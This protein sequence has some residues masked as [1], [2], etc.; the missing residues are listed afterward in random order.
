[1]DDK[2]KIL[3]I[4]CVSCNKETNHLVEWRK[5]WTEDDGIEQTG[6]WVRYEI[7]VLKCMGCDEYTFRKCS[8]CSE[9]IYPVGEDEEGN[10]IV[11]YEENIIFY[12][13]R[14]NKLIHE[15]SEIYL[16][17][18]EVR[19]IYSETLFAINNSLPL[20]SG[21]GIRGIIEAICS[22]EGINSGSIKNK[23]QTMFD[24]GIITNTLKEGLQENRLLG[25]Y[26]VHQL[27]SGSDEEL[28][29]AMELINIL[30]K[31]HYSVPEKTEILKKSGRV[32]SF[33]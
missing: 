13:D 15:I 4:H 7:E 24:N 6:I 12:P 14:K 25:N 27:Y 16:T 23:I 33:H 8:M 22:S 1:M 21:I 17:P 9:D 2:T 20:L 5:A 10:A 19:K 31:T 28:Q 3:K 18:P 30:I 26:S 29:A 11:D 32:D